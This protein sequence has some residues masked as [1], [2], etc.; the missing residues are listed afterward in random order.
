VLRTRNLGQFRPSPWQHNEPFR[1]VGALDDLDMH[2][3]QTCTRTLFEN[4]PLITAICEQLAHEGIEPEQGRDQ[5]HTTIAILD[6]G[7][8]HDGVHQQALGI[9][10]NMPLLAV[11]F[12]ACI[13]AM[14]SMQAPLFR[15]SLPSGCR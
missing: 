11:D 12:F 7:R 15:R 1:A 6:V 9:D 5:Q 4:R 10:Q 3:R 8:M 14:G 13:V 2:L